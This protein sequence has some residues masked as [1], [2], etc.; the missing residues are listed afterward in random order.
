MKLTPLIYIFLL[1]GIHNSASANFF[2]GPISSAMGGAGRAGLAS[3]EGAFLNPAVIPLVK[4]YEFI[5]FYRDGYV[6]DGHHRQGLAVGAVDNSEGVVFPGAAHYG[7]IRDT[8]RST[9]GAEGEI[10]HIA[11]AY[12][13]S[14]RFSVGFSAYRLLF[15]DPIKEYVQWNGSLGTVILVNENISVAYVLDN[16]AKPGSEVPRG[17]RQDMRQSI[18][19]FGRVEDILG[20]RM[21]VEREERFNVDKKMTYMVG[22][23]SLMSEFFVARLGYRADDR[24]DQ[25][26]WTAGFGFNGPRLKVDYAVEKPQEGTSGA[27]HSVDLR[28]PF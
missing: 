18:G 27:L 17:M 6:A 8:G 9:G 2:R 12:L 20:V 7:K 15:D 13:F 21:D 3:S 19:F 26:F 23:E 24:A 14:D 10:W 1:I 25:R 22:L 5:L 28:I 16:I 11:G 4:N